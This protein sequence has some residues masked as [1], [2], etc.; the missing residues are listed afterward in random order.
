MT[1]KVTQSIQDSIYRMRKDRGIRGDDLSKAVG[2]SPAFISRIET[3]KTQTIDD[4]ILFLIFKEIMGQDDESVREYIELF[5]DMVPDTSNFDFIDSL[6]SNE[7]LLLGKFMSFVR[8]KENSFQFLNYVLQAIELSDRP[9]DSLDREGIDIF[10]LTLADIMQLWKN[11]K[12]QEFEK[13]QEIRAKL[14]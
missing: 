3:G 11:Q 6:S 12:K 8:D 14:E 5:I 4:S 10:P 2:K 7:K 9:T 1:I 13:F